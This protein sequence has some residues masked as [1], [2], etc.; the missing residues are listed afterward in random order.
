MLTRRSLK[1]ALGF[2][3]ATTALEEQVG[4]GAT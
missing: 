1:L 3:R 4:A 2:Q